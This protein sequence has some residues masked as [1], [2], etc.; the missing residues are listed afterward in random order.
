MSVRIGTQALKALTVTTASSTADGA[1]VGAYV[2][3]CDVGEYDSARVRSSAPPTTAAGEMPERPTAELM[4]YPVQR[5][6]PAKTR[7]KTVK[8]KILAKG[9]PRVRLVPVTN[10]PS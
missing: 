10:A 4:P 7:A 6:V 5:A 2:G 3:M 8:D 1:Y 9:Y